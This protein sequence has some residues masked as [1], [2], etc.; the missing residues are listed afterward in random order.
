[1]RKPDKI[2]LIFYVLA[3]CAAL[4]YPVKKILS[5][6]RPAIPPKLYLFETE[7]YDPYDPMRGRYVRLNFKQNRVRLPQKNMRLMEWRSGNSCFAVLEKN[8]DGT[9]RI[10]DLVTDVKQVPDG[11]DFLRVRY[12]H[13]QWDFDKTTHKQE[14]TGVHLIQLPF[15]RFY[16][17]E[18]LAPEA[19]REVQANTRKG[20]AHLRVKIYGNGNFAVDDL[21]V[22]GKPILERLRDTASK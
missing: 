20:K 7:I 9:T 12:S 13:F 15:D 5:F 22:D 16:L 17:N 11:K 10:A 6:E 3:V 8:P 4:A 1:M 19:E 2:R 14:K 21:I 18:S